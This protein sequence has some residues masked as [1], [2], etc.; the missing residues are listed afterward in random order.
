VQSLF[1]ELAAKENMLVPHYP[2]LSNPFRSKRREAE[3]FEQTANRV[4]LVPLD[5][6]R[7]AGTLSGGNA[8]KLVV[9]RWMTAVD[10]TCLLLLDEPTQGVDVGARHDLY[11]LFKAYASKPGH[12]VIFSS[13]DPEEI[14]ALADRVVVLVGGEVADIVSPSIG[15]EALLTLA[16]S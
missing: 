13:S 14:V 9:G 6:D 1:S 2:A 10:Q 11:K 7:E 16:H 8:Q 4:G 15:E 3:I 5:P 12:A